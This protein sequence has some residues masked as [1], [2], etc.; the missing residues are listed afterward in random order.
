VQV[1]DLAEQRWQGLV[2]EHFSLALA[3][4]KH[5]LRRPASRFTTDVE[6]SCIA[7]CFDKISLQ[8]LTYVTS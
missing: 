4:S 1:R 3:H 2:L 6:W 8:T 7:A 5:A